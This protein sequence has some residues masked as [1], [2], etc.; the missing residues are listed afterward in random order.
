MQIDKVPKSNNNEIK[1]INKLLKLT[2]ARRM[3]SLQTTVKQKESKNEYV[4][5]N[6]YISV[7]AYVYTFSVKS[8]AG[9]NKR[10]AL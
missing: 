8:N 10:D 1:E 5:I 2:G 3:L 6:I 4:Y 9:H 7:G